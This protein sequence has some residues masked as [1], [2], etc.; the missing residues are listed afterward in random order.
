[1]QFRTVATAIALT[2]C[3]SGKTIVDS[4]DDTSD[5]TDTDTP[6]DTSEPTDSD[7]PADTSEPTDTGESEDS[8]ESAD[9]SEPTDTGEPADTGETETSTS[10]THW[11]VV[12]MDDVADH[13]NISEL[14]FYADKECTVSLRDTIESVLTVTWNDCDY[15]G[16]GLLNNGVEMFSGHCD[17]GNWANQPDSSGPGEIWAGYALSEASPVECVTISQSS[18]ATQRVTKV[19]LENSPDDGDT[20]VPVETILTESTAL[21]ATTVFRRAE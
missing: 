13:W 3:A 18:D 20:W 4:T 15:G 7:E 19:T 10:S 21:W 1:V 17:A 6:A 14:T 12:N 16:P 5:A 2:A 9:T 11:R 8:G